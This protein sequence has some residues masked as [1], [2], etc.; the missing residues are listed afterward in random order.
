[1]L[2]PS[3][4]G[5]SVSAIGSGFI[6]SIIGYYTPLMLLGS[7]LMIVGFGFLTTLSLDS[8]HSAWIGWQAMFSLGLGLAFPQAWSATQA[9]LTPKDIPAGMA[10]VGFSISLGGAL[11]ISISQN[12][13]T[14]LLKQGLATVPGVDIDKIISRGATNLLENVPESSKTQVLVAYNHAITRTF[15]AAMAVACLGFIAA[16]LMEWKSVKVKK[17]TDSET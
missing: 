7:I 13:F 4:I 14:Q 16:L 11:F 10:A 8:D 12:I 1:M 17:E 5:L 2:L 6:L 3:I 15:W 9:A